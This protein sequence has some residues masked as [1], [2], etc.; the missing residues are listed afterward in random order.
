MLWFGGRSPIQFQFGENAHRHTH[1]QLV[2]VWIS[3]KSVQGL[4]CT[5]M[6]NMKLCTLWSREL[7]CTAFFILSRDHELFFFRF[8]FGR[9]LF[10]ISVRKFGYLISI[11]LDG[12]EYGF[13]KDINGFQFI[14]QINSSHIFQSV[15]EREREKSEINSKY[16]KCIQRTTN[17]WPRMKLQNWKQIDVPW[18]EIDLVHFLVQ[19][20]NRYHIKYILKIA[21][22]PFCIHLHLISVY[23][24]FKIKTAMRKVLVKRFTWFFRS[25]NFIHILISNHISFARTDQYYY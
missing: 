4:T 5:D 23:F 25:T 15:C 9:K 6:S 21:R 24:Q 10:W 7:F 19:H 16:S 2:W 1:S 20:W 8:T 22:I 13:S 14:L 11:F 3:N 17:I 12:V 18:N